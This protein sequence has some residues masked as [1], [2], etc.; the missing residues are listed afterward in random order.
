MNIYSS[1]PGGTFALLSG[2]SMA[3]PH[4]AGSAALLVAQHPTWT[5]DQIKS[6]LVTT[7]QRVVTT[8]PGGHTDAGV[9]RRGGGLI[10]LSEAGNVIAAFT[11]ASVGFGVHEAHG[12]TTANQTVTVTNVTNAAQT[13]NLTVSQPGTATARFTVSPA[14][15]MIA[16]NGTATFTVTVS[17]RNVTLNGPFKDFEGDAVVTGATG[18]SMQLPLWA[19]F[20]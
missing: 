13:F 14:T 15:L 6:A 17:A 11:P 12:V 1:V 8:V 20:K 16:A 5:T 3:T 19:R 2:T 9:L 7:A 4:T 10:D 18:P